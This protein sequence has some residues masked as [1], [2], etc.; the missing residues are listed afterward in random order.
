M[1]HWAER[2]WDLYAM[3]GRTQ[4]ELGEQ[5]GVHPQHVSS[6]VCRRKWAWLD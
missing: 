2:F 1:P 5:F 4:R 6:I 3:G